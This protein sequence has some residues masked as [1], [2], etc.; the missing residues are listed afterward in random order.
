MIKSAEKPPRTREKILESAVETFADLGYEGATTRT[1]ADAAG[2]NVGL[3]KYYFESKA[4][5]WREA[6]DAAFAELHD[7]LGDSLTG[8]E[9]VDADARLRTVAR[10]FTRFVS[11]KPSVV[12]FMQD[13]GTHDGERMR[14]L[15]DRHLRPVYERLGADIRELQEAGSFPSGIAPVHFFY[16]IVG[17]T[18]LLFHQAPE[19][20]YLTGVDPREPDVADAHADALWRVFTFG[21]Q[22][23]P[24][25]DGS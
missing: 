20:H 9:E 24:A 22:D 11:A 10:R 5:L 1:I 7:A 6:A 23:P 8:L 2:V 15:V 13:A 17:A 18:T 12:R 14:W 16:L 3:I 4:L 21:K 19:C 25:G